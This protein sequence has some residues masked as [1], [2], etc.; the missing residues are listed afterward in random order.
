[1]WPIL[2][3]ML[4]LIFVILK[5]TLFIYFGDRYIYHCLGIKPRANTI[6][7]KGRDVL[8]LVMP[9]WAN[10]GQVLQRHEYDC[11]SQWLCGGK[12]IKPK[13]SKTY[14]RK[15]RVWIEKKECCFVSISFWLW[16]SQCGE[17]S[18][19][20]AFYHW[21]SPYLAWFL[22]VYSSCCHIVTCLNPFKTIYRLSIIQEC[23]RARSAEVN[24][25]LRKEDYASIPM[26]GIYTSLYTSHIFQS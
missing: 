15:K 9:P 10:F 1:M 7:L 4:A 22:I 2:I 20:K 24:G 23:V 19:C 14:I 26:L 12:W 25:K 5:H 17:V 13:L 18:P 11:A 3:D 6:K 16:C 8:D 21:L